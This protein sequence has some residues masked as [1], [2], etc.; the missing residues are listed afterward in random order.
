MPRPACAVISF[1]PDAFAASFFSRRGTLGP[2]NGHETSLLFMK[3]TRKP[4]GIIN[5]LAAGGFSVMKRTFDSS[6]QCAT[7]YLKTGAIVV[8]DV[9]DQNVWLAGAYRDCLR[10]KKYFETIYFRGGW[11]RLWAMR[12]NWFSRQTPLPSSAGLP[13]SGTAEVVPSR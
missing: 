1:F 12:R 7:L 9:E 11:A 2:T 6:T 5:D 13:L 10:V 3:T 8:C 4:N